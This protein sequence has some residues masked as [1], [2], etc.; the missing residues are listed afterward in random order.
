VNGATT[1]CTAT[2]II[3]EESPGQVTCDGRIL[4]RELLD[5]GQGKFSSDMDISNSSSNDKYTPAPTTTTLMR[6]QSTHK[7]LCPPIIESMGVITTGA[8][9]MILCKQNKAHRNEKLLQQPVTTQWIM[10][11]G[12]TILPLDHWEQ[13]EKTPTKRET[14]L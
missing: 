5:N 7:L 3:D 8:T 13:R 14:A 12:T 6:E 11:K 10:H 4:P 9:T 1:A 2:R